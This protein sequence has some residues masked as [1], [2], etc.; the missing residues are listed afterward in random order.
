MT[1][2]DY[3]LIVIVVMGLITLGLRALPFVAGRWLRRQGIV[4]KL[5]AT[6][7][8]SIMTLLLLHSVVDAA[9]QNPAGAWQEALA[10]VMVGL[11]QWRTRNTLLSIVAGTSAYVVM[12]NV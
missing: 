5:G 4:H 8:L 10:V 12:R 7:P 2:T 6:L 11:I 9:R 3:V 1:D